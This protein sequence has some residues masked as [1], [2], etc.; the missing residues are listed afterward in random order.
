LIRTSNATLTT[1]NIRELIVQLNRGNSEKALPLV[2]L[3]SDDL[4]AI[5]GSGMDAKSGPMQQAQQTKFAIDEVRTLLGERDLRGALDAA[6]DAG[7]EW[8]VRP[9]SGRE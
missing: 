7:K 2:N 9:E 5:L 3:V 8:Q 4:S 1:A 6:R